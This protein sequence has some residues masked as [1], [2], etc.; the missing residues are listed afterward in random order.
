MTIPLPIRLAIPIVLVSASRQQQAGGRNWA[1]VVYERRLAGA[2]RP[3]WASSG[4]V[5]LDAK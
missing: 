3:A 4:Y 1:W 2:P 5:D